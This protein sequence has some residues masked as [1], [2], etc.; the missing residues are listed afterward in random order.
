[1]GL[2]ESAID[3]WV[4]EWLAR[5]PQ[6]LCL[7]EDAE[8][9]LPAVSYMT[10]SPRERA[11]ILFTA[12]QRR[13]GQSFGQ[14]ITR[15]ERPLD[16]VGLSAAVPPFIADSAFEM[17]KVR[18]AFAHC[19]GRADQ[20]FIDDCPWFNLAVGD[21]IPLNIYVVHGYNT[22]LLSYV[23]ML[24]HRGYARVGIRLVGDD[25]QQY[26]DRSIDVGLASAGA[27]AEYLGSLPPCV[28]AVPV[29]QTRHASLLTKPED[30]TSC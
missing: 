9:K 18:N 1:L 15:F 21:E 10:T 11:E 30:T 20:R 27:E 12:L 26:W 14:G 3:D 4:V 19:G 29:V 5:R 23:L 28:G 24:V 25:Y 16:L 22:V 6:D 2:L 8:L 17:H 13:Q 7:K